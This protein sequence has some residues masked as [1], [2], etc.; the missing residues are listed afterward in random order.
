MPNVSLQLVN[1]QNPSMG[2]VVNCAGAAGGEANTVLTDADRGGHVL[3]GFRRCPR[4]RPVLYSGGS[5]RR[6]A[7]SD[8]TSPPFANWAIG[9]LN[10]TVTAA[11]PGLIKSHA[12]Q[13]PVRRPWPSPGIRAPGGSG[14]RVGNSGGRPD[15]E[16][17]RDS[18][19]RRQSFEHHHVDGRE[20]PGGGHRD[21]RGYR[22]GRRPN[23]SDVPRLP[24]GGPGP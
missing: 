10:L 6:A 21:F 3:A 8:P 9:P 22:F 5:G 15:G 2:P 4:D 13:R 20:R 11:Q 16:L 23:H 1:Y 24:G 7:P 17:D 12:G 18:G 19:R 14:H